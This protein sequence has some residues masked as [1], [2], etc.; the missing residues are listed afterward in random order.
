VDPLFAPTLVTSSFCKVL[1]SK[2]F[3]RLLGLIHI[4]Y[5]WGKSTTDKHCTSYIFVSQWPCRLVMLE[6]FPGHVLCATLTT[7]LFSA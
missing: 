4:G 6:E 7:F 1:V 3:M 5:S 2:V